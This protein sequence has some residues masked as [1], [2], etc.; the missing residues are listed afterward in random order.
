ML[1]ETIK[2]KIDSV[3]IDARKGE[4][5][6]SAAKRAGIEIPTLCYFE[7]IEPLGTCRICQVEDVKRGVL[8]ASC[9]TPVSEGMEIRTDTE[10]VQ[11]ARK[12]VAQLLLSSHPETCL[13]CDSHGICELRRVCAI[14]GVGTTSMEKVFP[15]LR[16]EN[17]SGFIQRDLMKCILCGR[18]VYACRNIIVQG[19][20]D[21]TNRGFET[22]IA[23]ADETPPAPPDCIQCGV[24]IALCPTGALDAINKKIRRQ[25]ENKKL[26]ICNRCGCGCL[27]ELSVENGEIVSKMPFVRDGRIETTCSKGIF[28]VGWKDE[29]EKMESAIISPGAGSDGGEGVRALEI[30]EA[31]NFASKRISNILSTYG[32]LSVAFWCSPLASCEE[33][34]MLQKL[35]REFI[36]TPYIDVGGCGIIK[37]DSGVV[38]EKEGIGYPSLCGIGDIENA[39]LILLIG[40][41]LLDRAPSVE[42]AIRRGV[43]AGKSRVVHIGSTAQISLLPWVQRSIVV[44]REMIPILVSLIGRMLL[45]M[46]PKNFPPVVDL[47][48]DIKNEYFENG[49]SIEG[50]DSSEIVRIAE[51]IFSAQRLVIV[52]GSDFKAKKGHVIFDIEDAAF[53]AHASWHSEREMAAIVPAIAVSNEIGL[54]RC[55]VHPGLQTLWKRENYADGGVQGKQEIK[56]SNSTALYSSASILGNIK[57]S[58]IKVLLAFGENAIDFICEKHEVDKEKEME[59]ILK[60]LELLVV[61]DS[62]LRPEHKHAHVFI[63]MREHEKKEG[64]F[65]GIDGIAKICFPVIS[66]KEQVLPDGVKILTEFISNFSRGSGEII[67]NIGDVREEMKRKGILSL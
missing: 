27:L 61:V 59:E 36:A 3:S 22:F 8:V 18:C 58:R 41:E 53:L 4:T 24:C 16:W 26:S 54:L 46:V 44:S 32:S 35:A 25:A 30:K 66:N 65:I 11:N 47:G 10:K 1:E 39:D 67:G 34:F 45:S 38:Y 20:I 2:I 43:V 9:V 28:G 37:A 14:L 23:T 29:G 15:S 56:E 42:F 12:I 6:L 60:K 48:R 64:T 5:I 57:T 52:V 31:I 17:P 21:Y 62:K 51:E 19:A 13:V 7:G 55:G 49:I 63:P 50:I 40:D 33:G